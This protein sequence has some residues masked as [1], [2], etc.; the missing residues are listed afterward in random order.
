MKNRLLSLLFLLPLVVFAQK[1]S[2][3]GVFEVKCDS[4]ALVRQKIQSMLLLRE[5]V[6]EEG[7]NPVTKL[8]TSEFNAYGLPVYVEKS[9]NFGVGH[10][11]FDV[12]TKTQQ[13]LGYDSKQR[14][15]SMCENK[16]GQILCQELEYDDDGNH[17]RVA[18]YGGP[19]DTVEIFMQWKS[20]KMVKATYKN[21]SGKSVMRKM[22]E[23]GKM[24]EYRSDNYHLTYE[25]STSG[26]EETTTMYLYLEDTLYS[27]TVFKS[28]S[29]GSLP[30]YFAGFDHKRDTL[31]L[32]MATYDVHGNVTSF[33]S[34]DYSNRYY[35]EFDQ[36]DDGPFKRTDSNKPKLKPEPMVEKLELV[37]VYSDQNLLVK[38][39]I[40]RISTKGERELA[41]IDRLIYEKEPLSSKPWP[42]E[43]EGIEYWD[44][45]R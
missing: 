17:I 42:V 2:D 12:L 38:R 14:L 39:N 26:T 41:A 4:G 27:I 21:E 19:T 28:Q 18:S 16:R 10:S 45:G 29:D 11:Y 5:Y 43:E 7:S 32:M 8:M 31:K 33:E 30:T 23:A 6:T 44:E 24:T 35:P 22:N 13:Q 36:E 34:R 40:Y 1:N 9:T 37:N 20:G 25:Y 3:N 15:N